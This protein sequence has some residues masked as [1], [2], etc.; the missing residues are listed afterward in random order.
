MGEP[1]RRC[2]PKQPSCEF[3]AS[4]PLWQRCF[5]LLIST[6]A[7]F[8]EPETN[9]GESFFFSK[10]GVCLLDW[11]FVEIMLFPEPFFQFLPLFRATS[12]CDVWG[13]TVQSHAFL[14]R[15]LAKHYA[16]VR[17]LKPEESL[18]S[19][20]HRFSRLLIGSATYFCSSLMNTHHYHIWQ[21]TSGVETADLNSWVKGETF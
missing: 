10:W 15:P 2:Q 14:H 5:Q 4:Q 1:E 6:L 21:Q 9:W 8:R 3:A 19:G 11:V 18:P 17:W 16:G 20:I 12:M 7:P 13:A